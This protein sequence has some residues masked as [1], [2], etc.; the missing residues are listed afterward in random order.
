MK[1]GLVNMVSKNTA[2]QTREKY[3]KKLELCH[4]VIVQF[5][6]VFNIG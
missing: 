5:L 6:K 3:V 4:M 1:N 2:G